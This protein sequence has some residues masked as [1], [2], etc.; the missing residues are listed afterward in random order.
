MEKHITVCFPEKSSLGS[1]YTADRDFPHPRKWIGE[2]KGKRAL[3]YPEAKML[4]VAL[5]AVGWEGLAA[6]NSDELNCLE[7][8][9]FSTTQFSEKTLRSSTGLLGLMEI[10]L[11][12]LRFGDKDIDILSIFPT[13]QTLWLT[14]TEVSDKG[15][16]NLAKLPALV[17]LV[18]K[19][20]T[21]SD[22]GLTNLAPLKTLESLTL[23][24]HTGD[25]GLKNLKE[26]KSL[27]RLDLSFTK[28]TDEGLGNLAALPHLQELYLSDTKVTDKGIHHLTK[29]PSLRVIFL[30]G[31]K[32][33]DQAL[34]HMEKLPAL[35]HLELR[36]TGVTEIGQARLK[37]RIP[38]CAIFGP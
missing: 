33:S 17:N 6:A 15:M 29:V 18:L 11:D 28:V 36:D 1:L 32:V 13:L 16:D 7:S 20:T 4:G 34:P 38:E 9:D 19:S 8:I 31:T 2:A 35:E 22:A 37:S 21:V 10:R 26:L 27:K 23:P 14:G 3:V 25:E 24:A 30:S 12:F 5:G